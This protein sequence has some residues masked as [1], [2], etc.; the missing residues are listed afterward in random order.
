MIKVAIAGDFG[1]IHEG[2]VDHIMKAYAMGDWLTVITHTD[3]SILKRKSY[4]PIALWTRKILLEGLI[5]RLGG[6]GEVIIAIDT[7]GK[8]AKTLEALRPQILAKG[9]DRNPRTMPQEEIDVC[10]KIGCKIVYK[11]GELLNSSTSLA[12][13]KEHNDL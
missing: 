8:C 4:K 2:H 13:N 7:D 5:M 6:K 1:I 9:G 10:D 3:D 11:V 12:N